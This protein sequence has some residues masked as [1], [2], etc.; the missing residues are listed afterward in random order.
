M[1]RDIN[2]KMSSCFDLGDWDLQTW[3]QRRRSGSICQTMVLKL[4]T[5][6]WIRAK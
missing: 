5:H 1:K 6:S 4:L 3:N 2:K